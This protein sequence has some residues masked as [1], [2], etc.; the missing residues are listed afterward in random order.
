M[1]RLIENAN[2]QLQKHLFTFWKINFFPL[3][4]VAAI[5]EKLYGSDVPPI[6]LVGHR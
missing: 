6:V 4:D 5:I 2:H 3:S 1:Y